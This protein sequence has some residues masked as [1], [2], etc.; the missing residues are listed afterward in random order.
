MNKEF[1]NI[2]FSIENQVAK[3]SL[4]RPNVLNSF[5]YH[6]ADE[7]IMAFM[8]CKENKNIRA[9]ILTGEGRAFCAGQDLEE[10]TGLNAPSID[11]I[12]EH[13]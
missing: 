6:M 10:A 1:K 8:H 13:T 9:I 11:K 12:I 3:I 5:N 4:N 7:V 2:I